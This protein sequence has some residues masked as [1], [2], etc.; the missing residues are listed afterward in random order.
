MGLPSFLL[1]L[2]SLYAT[3]DGLCCAL[4]L[5]LLYEALPLISSVSYEGVLRPG[6]ACHFC[7]E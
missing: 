2:A 1:S 5:M 4:Y 3:G 7:Q 6:S